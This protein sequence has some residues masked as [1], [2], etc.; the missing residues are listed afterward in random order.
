MFGLGP[1]ELIVALLLILVLF[2]SKKVPEMMRG[3]GEGMKELKKAA[4]EDDA[5]PSDRT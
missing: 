2:G 1:N 3:L 5:K 4:H